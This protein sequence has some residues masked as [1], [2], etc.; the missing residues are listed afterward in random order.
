LAKVEIFVQCFIFAFMKK[1]AKPSAPAKKPP[2]GRPQHVPTGANRNIVLMAKGMLDMPIRQIAQV[3]GI[4]EKTL[5]R[6]YEKE[7]EEAQDKVDIEVVTNLYMQ[8]KGR[9]ARYDDKN[10]KI[11]EEIKPNPNS[12]HFYLARRLGWR[13]TAPRVPQPV[14]TK[15]MGAIDLSLCTPEELKVMEQLF[16]RQV[17]AEDSANG[18]QQQPLN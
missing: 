12:I 5:R 7:L 14:D 13:E 15:G 16:L 6:H 8:I 10:N 18:G 9:P 4:D 11:Q 2:I 1:P 17:R 3:L